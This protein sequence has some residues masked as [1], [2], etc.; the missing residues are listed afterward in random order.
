[1]KWFFLCPLIALLVS[2]NSICWIFFSIYSIN[3]TINIQTCLFF[4][5][6][7]FW[8]GFFIQIL[9]NKKDRAQLT[10]MF[11]ITLFFALYLLFF[12]TVGSNNLH[13]VALTAICK[14]VFCIFFFY[15]L[16]KNLFYQ[17][18]LKEPAFWIVT[19]LI[20]YS[21]LSLPFYGLNSYLKFQFST[22]VSSNLHTV[23][24]ILIIIMH[25]FF[26]KAYLC[27]VRVYKV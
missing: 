1:M 16:F 17:N 21:T 12:S 7:F 19:G 20:F 4:I 9:S 18:I 6:L 10:I 27:T 24:N 13:I 25:L 5:D 14:T 26:I 3:S 11:S 22:L 8:F 15:K 2:V 23:S